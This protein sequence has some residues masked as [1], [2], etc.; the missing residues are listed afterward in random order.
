MVE[1]GSCPVQDCG[2]DGCSDPDHEERDTP[3]GVCEFLQIGGVPTLA[4]L[5]VDA[6]DW[7]A[8]DGFAEFLAHTEWTRCE[9]EDAA[10]RPFNMGSVD[11]RLCPS[12]YTLLVSTSLP[13]RAPNTSF[14]S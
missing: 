13:T 2:S 10:S 7:V 14:V 11:G 9:A 5:S 6:T 4:P 1:C 3:C 12:L 8:V